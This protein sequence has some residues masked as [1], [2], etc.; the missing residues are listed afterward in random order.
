MEGHRA[1]ALRLRELAE[2]AGRAAALDDLA[3][4]R[5]QFAAIRREWHDLGAGM[6]ND[7]AVTEQYAAAQTAFA[8]RDAAAHEQDQKA[9]R[10]GLIPRSSWSAASRRSPAAP[11]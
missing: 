1:P 4:A 11:I 6:I 2:E 3:A 10:E 9:R 8:A 7:P 5:K